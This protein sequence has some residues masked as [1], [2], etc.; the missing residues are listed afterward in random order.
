LNRDCQ[1][2]KRREWHSGGSN[3]IERLGFQCDDTLADG[4]VFGISAVTRWVSHCE[5]LIASLESRYT[6][7]NFFHH[8]RD[9]PTGNEWK[10]VSRASIQRTRS[11][12]PIERIYARGMNADEQFVFL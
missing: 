7:A 10:R 3:V 4:D 9:V 5:D 6:P 1:A 12:L 11:H 2:G 8:S